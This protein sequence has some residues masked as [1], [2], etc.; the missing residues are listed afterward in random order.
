M[1]AFGYAGT[2]FDELWQ[3]ADP[4]E[5]LPLELGMS[6]PSDKLGVR[7][8][9]DGEHPITRLQVTVAARE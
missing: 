3:G 9:L 1:A 5:R 6:I 2:A 8:D 4:S 7:T